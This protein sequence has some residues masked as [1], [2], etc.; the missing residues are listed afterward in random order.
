[1][2]IS[3]IIV[4]I[5]IKTLIFGWLIWTLHEKDKCRKIIII[6]WAVLTSLVCDGY[7]FGFSQPEKNYQP[8]I[9]KL[10]KYTEEGIKND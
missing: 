8:W 3:I 1:M 7:Q 4:W 10:A 2:T 5:I 9:L 6:I